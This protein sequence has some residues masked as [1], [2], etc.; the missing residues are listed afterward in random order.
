[1]YPLWIFAYGFIGSGTDKI[2]PIQKLT[3]NVSLSRNLKSPFIW[4]DH[5][6]EER[7]WWIKSKRFV[8]NLWNSQRINNIHWWVVE[9]MALSFTS[10]DHSYKWVKLWIWSDIY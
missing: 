5:D 3:S 8:N 1:M 4:G 9:P 7:I 6:T 10:L 2:I